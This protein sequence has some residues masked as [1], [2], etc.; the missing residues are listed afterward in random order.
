VTGLP[1]R[2]VRGMDEVLR[3]ST[4]RERFHMLLMSVFGGMSLLL[5]AIGIYGLMA[6]SVEQRT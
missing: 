6:F 5:Q 1:V 2:D 3:R 4:S